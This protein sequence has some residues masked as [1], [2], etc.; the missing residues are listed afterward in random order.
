MPGNISGGILNSDSAMSE[1]ATT[2]ETTVSER[3]SASTNWTG[4]VFGILVFFAGVALLLFVFKLAYDQFNVP[5]ENALHIDAGKALDVT[6][7]VQS[8]A[9]LI[10]R[11]LL[12]I[13][14]AIVGALIANR[15]IK[16]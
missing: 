10:I 3:K 12:L 14:M 16:M 6:K 7:A 13:V 5:P 1:P 9:G 4:A 11:V 2:V 8:F 15:G